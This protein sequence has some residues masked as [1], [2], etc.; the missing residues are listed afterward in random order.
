MGACGKIEWEF[1]APSLFAHR[2][3]VRSISL[4]KWSKLSP[5]ATF[6]MLMS[7]LG[8]LAGNSHEAGGRGGGSWDAPMFWIKVEERFA[9]KFMATVQVISKS[10]HLSSL[11]SPT[12]VCYFF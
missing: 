8:E 12:S 2:H 9:P 10:L 6:L 11:I 1:T 4:W 5:T 7:P 3:S